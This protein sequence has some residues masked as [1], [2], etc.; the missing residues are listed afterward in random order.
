[1][2]GRNVNKHPIGLKSAIQIGKKK[3]KQSSLQKYQRASYYHYSLDSVPII[4]LY[5]VMFLCNV[6][7][8]TNI[9]CTT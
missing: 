1:M 9:A 6:T 2:I 7:S 4:N 8:K 3:H 5:N